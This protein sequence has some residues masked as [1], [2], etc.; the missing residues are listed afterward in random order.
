M[1]GAKREPERPPRQRG[2]RQP[3]LRHQT[4][5]HQTPRQQGPQH[6]APRQRAH[7]LGN[8]ALALGSVVV[9]LG[10]FEAGVRLARPELSIPQAAQH[11]RFSQSSEFQLPH[12]RRDPVLGWT[13]K[14]GRYGG[15]QINSQGFRGPELA[16][17]KPPRTLRIA[18]LGDS[19]T[20]GFTLADDGDVYGAVLTA[21]LARD[22]LAA[23]TLNFGVDGYSSHQGRLLLDRVLGQEPD[24]VTFYFGY[25]DH[26]FSNASD[27]ETRFT[28]PLRLLEA[29]HA[30]RFMRRQILKLG[31]RE[32]RLVQPIRR[33]DLS[34]FEANLRA[35]VER[36]R[37]GGAVP[38]LMTTALR[39]GIP[40][41]ENEVLA[42][43]PG[44]QLD[45]QPGRRQ[46]SEPG[47][48]L[49]REGS[50]LPGRQ[51]WVTQDWWVSRQLESRGVRP[52]EAAGT[53]ALRQVLDEGLRRYP[54]WPYLHYLRAREL[55]R[56]GDAAGARA[57]L[58]RAAAT[59]AERRVMEA[60]N[61]KVRSVARA[62]GVELVDLARE[63]EARGSQPLLNDVVHP[64][65]A[66]HALIAE[67]LAGVVL[68]LEGRSE[69]RSE[70]RF[71][72]G[73]RIASRIVQASASK[74]KDQPGGGGRGRDAR[75]RA[76][77]L[78]GD[79]PGN[80]MQVRLLRRSL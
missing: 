5:Q 35:M 79:R 23:E 73:P 71:Q 67:Q 22:G 40:L 8:L 17:A 69:R 38:I 75:Y 12:H 10:L 2:R 3:G 32:A 31:R 15:M 76:G 54:D 66:G 39:S 65:R 48:K 72:V 64:S 11:F 25:N 18:H 29:S 21:F 4:P 61:D 6:Q 44:R 53:E 13:L 41:I 36:A 19:C 16:P 57:A 80:R 74:S 51:L 42:E 50:H 46:D 55:Q 7:W 62:L 56:A 43:E 27:R 49:D 20:M 14:P 47:Q 77:H 30:Y 1:P 52:T 37:A 59:D 9:F 68:R 45:H 24:Y 60:Y 34:E 26:H 58:E 78:S 70:N 28:P 63:F 33:V